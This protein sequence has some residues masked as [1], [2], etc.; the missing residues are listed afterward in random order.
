MYHTFSRFVQVI[1]E[2]RA[3][4]CTDISLI[5]KIYRPNKKV[6]VCLIFKSWISNLRDLGFQ[7]LES[8]IS[9]LRDL[10]IQISESWI[11]N[12]R[13]DDQALHIS[14]LPSRPVGA[15]GGQDDRGGPPP[16]GGRPLQGDDDDDDDHYQPPPLLQFEFKFD[17]AHL[18]LGI[19]KLS[20]VRITPAGSMPSIR[21][22][23]CQPLRTTECI[24]PNRE[25]S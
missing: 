18:R 22:T 2:F 1:L 25:T 9:N 24:C 12:L 7:I 4:S 20:R 16:G 15:P 19:W 10:G 5:Q 23:K 8:W 6:F 17:I 14:L 13:N 3:Y 21:S 11:S